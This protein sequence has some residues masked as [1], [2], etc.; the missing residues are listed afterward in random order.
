MV[1]QLIQNLLIFSA[2]FV[3]IDKQIVFVLDLKAETTGFWW[4]MNVALSSYGAK[5]YQG[6][7][8]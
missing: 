2:Y 3:F 7:F 5:L 4:F 1:Q 6:F 8:L